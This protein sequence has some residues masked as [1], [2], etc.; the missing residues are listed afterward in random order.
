M[1][2]MDQTSA[3]TPPPGKAQR[4]TLRA[5]AALVVVLTGIFI[6]TVTTSRTDYIEYWSS[7]KLLIHH[8][9]PYSASDILKLEKAHGYFHTKPL[10]MFNPPWALFLVA[11]LGFLGLRQGLF[12]WIL[13]N[14]ACLFASAQLLDVT[15]KE[16]A[17]AYVF[18]P[19][20]A[21]IFMGQSSPILLLGFVLFLHFHRSQPFLAG[22]SLLLMFI[23][24]HLFFVYWAVLLADC[25]RRRSYLIPAGALSAFVAS[26][27]FPMFFDQHIW[28]HYRAMM[29]ASPV[30]QGFLPTA[31][32]LFRMFVDPHAFWLLFVPSGLAVLWGIWYYVTRR[33][34][35]DWNTH[36]MLLMLISILAAPYSW[37]TDEVVLL[38]SILYGLTYSHKRKHSAW[39]LLAINTAA[40]F[41]VLVKQES[42]STRAY[43]WTPWA[44]VAWFLYSTYGFSQNR[45]IAPV[46]TPASAQI[47]RAQA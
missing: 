18:A 31:S 24:P 46:E 6:L 15:P 21:S 37:L 5:T 36:G 12:L 30:E 26:N 7:G 10:I 14:I 43:M 41:I 45:E 17:F 34:E 4:K 35:W 1:E 40:L 16:R 22:A 38:P 23:K 29:Q 27:I 13:L 9:N 47:E 25:I 19:A 20:V 44:W 2:K 3:M 8:L 39:I 33:R 42:L 32:M 11:P 28:Q